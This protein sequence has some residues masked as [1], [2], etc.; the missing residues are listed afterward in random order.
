MIGF[1]LSIRGDLK[2][3]LEYAFALY[4]AD[5]NGHLDSDEIRDVITRMLDLL[6]ANK[7][8]HDTQKLALDCIKELDSS[9]DGKVSKGIEYIESIIV[10]V[11]FI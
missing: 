6:G 8:K 1:A 2:T 9:K 7:N 3:K 5:N 4:D 11:F 10:V